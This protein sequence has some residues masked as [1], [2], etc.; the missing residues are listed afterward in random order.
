MS[1]RAREGVTIFSRGASGRTEAATDNKTHEAQAMLRPAPADIRS[2]QFAAVANL[3]VAN[4]PI[5]GLSWSDYHTVID[6]LIGR[7]A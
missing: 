3:V 6:A 1:H 2:R 7:A 4:Q 5:A